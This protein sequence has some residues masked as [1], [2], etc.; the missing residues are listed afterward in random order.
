MTMQVK[1]PHQLS[2]RAVLAIGMLVVVFGLDG[3]L[4]EL[5]PGLFSREWRGAESP[6]PISMHAVCK[7]PLD[8]VV[9]GQQ[10]LVRCPS[11]WPFASSV[12]EVPASVVAPLNGRS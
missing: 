4:W 7:R 9:R 2:T 1:R 5:A 12:W 10:A 6:T 11:S 3:W 8:V